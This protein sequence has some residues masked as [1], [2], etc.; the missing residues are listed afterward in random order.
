MSQK[1]L[2]WEL[3]NG[4]EFRK[5]TL[6]SSFESSDFC[7]SSSAIKKI[8]NIILIYTALIINMSAILGVYLP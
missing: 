6:L 8:L 4:W 5:A 3:E 2:W 7:Y 1:I